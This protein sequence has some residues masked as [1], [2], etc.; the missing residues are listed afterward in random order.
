VI[1]SLPNQQPTPVVRER[2]RTMRK[3]LATVLAS[4]TVAAT[5]PA[6]ASA[7]ITRLE[8]GAQAELGPEG[9]FV[10]VPLTYQCDFFDGNISLFVE[11]A[12]S[13]GNRIANGAGFASG[14]CTG[15]PQTV[16]VQVN[17]STGVP[18][19]HGKAVARGAGF[20]SSGFSAS[21]GPEEIRIAD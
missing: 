19:R 15:S 20:T 9:V 4:L 14:Q 17:S 16:L 5:L 6:T 21:D 10:N 13:R 18:Y 8:L 3:V 1:V 11:V 12:Q 7:A 2:A